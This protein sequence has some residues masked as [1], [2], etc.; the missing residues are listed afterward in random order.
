LLALA[1]VLAIRAAAFA[2]GDACWWCSRSGT[3]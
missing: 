1:L 2:H 3:L